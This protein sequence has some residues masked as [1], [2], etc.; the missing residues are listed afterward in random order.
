MLCLQ[1]RV[2]LHHQALTLF[3]RR[4]QPPPE[5]LPAEIRGLPLPISH[6]RE[7]ALWSALLSTITGVCEETVFR[8]FVP[9]VLMSVSGNNWLLTLLGQSVLF[10]LGHTQPKVGLAENSVVAGL[11]A[12]NGLGFG[13][14]YLLSGGDLVPAI[15]AH[16]LFDFVGFFKTWLDANEQLEYAESMVYEP[17]PHEMEVEVRRILHKT[18]SVKIDLR[19]LNS[20]KRLFYTFD[21]DKNR[22][23]SLS[24][25]RKGI[26]YL[27]LE[28]HGRPPL[29]SEVDQLFRATL[30]LREHRGGS[31]RLSFADFVRLYSMMMSKK[32]EKD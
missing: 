10:G 15:I 7:V 28:L 11:Q 5:F 6:W 1:C 30:Q 9:A 8:C 14:I 26:S 27:A 23:L 2:P 18:Q 32:Q 22:S 21:F 20:L 31:D 25:V 19:F 29:E 16:A 13:L 17:L 12:M 3:G 24:E 4:Q